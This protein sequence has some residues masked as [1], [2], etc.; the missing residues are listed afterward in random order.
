M[1]LPVDE[2]EKET[3]YQRG[4]KIAKNGEYQSGLQMTNLKKILAP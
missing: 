3:T 2:K 1:F 4:M